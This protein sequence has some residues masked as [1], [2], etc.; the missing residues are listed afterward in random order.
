MLFFFDGFGT[1]TQ[2]LFVCSEPLVDK[3]TEYDTRYADAAKSVRR[4]SL[5]PFEAPY[6]TVRE[7]SDRIDIVYQT[8]DTAIETLESDGVVEEITGNE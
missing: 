3:R 4:L 5:T 6:G 7:T 1:I 8:A 2:V